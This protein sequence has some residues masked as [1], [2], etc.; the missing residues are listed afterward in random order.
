MKT[1]ETLY[2]LFFSPTHTSQTI[3]QAVADGLGI[4]HE[5]SIN[6]TY[7]TPK[8]DIHIDG[9]WAVIAVPVYGG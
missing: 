7:H 4:K 3:A 1:K 5:V 6:L 8:E 2:T 9:G